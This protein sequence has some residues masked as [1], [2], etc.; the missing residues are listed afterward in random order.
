M[1]LEPEIK[2]PIAVEPEPESPRYLSAK[3]TRRNGAP[4]TEAE[5]EAAEAEAQVWARRANSC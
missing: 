1:S 4:M 3:A 5:I 2:S